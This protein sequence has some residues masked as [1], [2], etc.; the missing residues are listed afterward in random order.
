MSKKSHKEQPA[1]SEQ[2]KK[3]DQL[4]A[5]KFGKIDAEMRNMLQG[6]RLT[7][8]ELAEVKKIAEEKTA[9]LNSQ[10]QKLKADVERTKPEYEALMKVIA[11]KYKVDGKRMTLD[12]DSGV[13]HEMSVH[14]VK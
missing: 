14:K 4:D 1:V 2:I 9:I 11:K 5:L 13:I 7:E 10:L 6:I 3:L 8:Y 12:P